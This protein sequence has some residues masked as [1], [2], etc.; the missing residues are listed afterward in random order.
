MPC[1]FFIKT[2]HYELERK[3]LD[4]YLFGR[5]KP[6]IIMHVNSFIFGPIFSPESLAS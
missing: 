1:K 3:Q 5:S 4:D 6:L 2:I